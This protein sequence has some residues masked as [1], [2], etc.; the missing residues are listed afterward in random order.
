MQSA[1]NEMMEMHHESGCGDKGRR[2]VRAHRRQYGAG[3]QALAKLV[4]H[5]GA[6][7]VSQLVLL[8]LHLLLLLQGI[9]AQRG[10]IMAAS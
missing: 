8:L 6:A 10:R 4:C 9:V 1:A 3:Q 2:G 7:A 5:G